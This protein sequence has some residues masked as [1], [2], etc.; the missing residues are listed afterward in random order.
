MGPASTLA[1]HNVAT[2]DTVEL[3]PRIAHSAAAATEL[4]YLPRLFVQ[5]VLLL[6]LSS[7]KFLTGLNH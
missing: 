7:L 5:C 4:P 6:P 1:H 3:T 2:V